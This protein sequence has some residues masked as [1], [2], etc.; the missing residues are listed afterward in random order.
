MANNQENI[1]R[2]F[3]H[4]LFQNLARVLEK[5]EE[6]Q[7]RTRRYPSEEDTYSDL[8]YLDLLDQLVGTLRGVTHSGFF[9]LT[10]DDAKYINELADA[11]EEISQHVFSFCFPNSGSTIIPGQFLAH[12]MHTNIA[13]RPKY[14]VPESTLEELRGL[15]FSWSQIAKMFG[16]PRWTIYRRIEE[17]NLQNLQRFSDISD[18]E[19]DAVI[20]DYMSQHG[21]TTGEP[22]IS[23]YF[24]SKGIFIQRSRVRNS[25]NRLD[26]EN[27]VLRWGALISRRTYYVPWP[28]SLWHI[29]GHHSLIRWKFVI[30]GCVDGK[31]RK[32]MFLHC[33]TN[34]LS[35][36]V[37]ALFLNAIDTNGGLWPSRI[38]VDYGVENVSVCEAM[39]EKRGAGR[40]SF[41]AGPSTH[42][43]RI[44]RL[45]RDVFR[46]VA[47]AFYY[48][49]YA[50][51]Q[52]GL[53]NVEN[54]IHMFTLHLVYLPRINL[55]IEEFKN[56]YNE[57]RLRTEGNLTPN[58]I[59]AN[60]MVNE[61]NP[62][63]NNILD[64]APEDVEF[65][66]NDQEYASV[67]T[68]STNNLVVSPDE[69]ENGEEIIQHV[70]RHLDPNRD[71]AQMGIDIYLQALQLVIDR[72]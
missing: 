39:V 17:Y 53:L 36:T 4:E 61:E 29:D 56:S 11:F 30:H 33:N 46:C 47:V 31:S 66:G 44:E 13:G 54:P 68:E 65:Y 38:R 5:A 43:Q 42:N 52:T 34:N 19:M 6:I 1:S 18:E 23:G 21:N 10:S 3:G 35:Q 41:I 62:L 28:N 57:H 69:V 20:K 50:M 45:W 32:V 58:Q 63:A 70:Y 25:L 14:E 49:F 9:T 40:G 16:V 7:R 60:G 67:F 55:A 59:W 51:E 12:A 71:S 72:L 64:E 24:R 26:P 22:F 2:D 27:T 48:T 8:L 37:L 15:G